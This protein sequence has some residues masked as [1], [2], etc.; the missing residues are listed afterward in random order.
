[1]P[2][3]GRVAD[4]AF[5]FQ[6]RSEEIAT[7][8]RFGGRTKGVGEDVSPLSGRDRLAGKGGENRRQEA[9]RDGHRMPSKG[10]GE[11]MVPAT[12]RMKT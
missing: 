2:R 3:I 5:D 8:E 6:K 12:R 1:V 9:A 7:L 10:K 11:E 4:D